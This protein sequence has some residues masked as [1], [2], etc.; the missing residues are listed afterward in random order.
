MEVNP[1][2]RVLYYD[3]LGFEHSGTIL[4]TQPCQAPDVQEPDEEGEVHYLYLKDDRDE[5][6]IICY[7]ISQSYKWTEDAVC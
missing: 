3:Y 2:T 5:F 1:G 7:E 6:I 4:L